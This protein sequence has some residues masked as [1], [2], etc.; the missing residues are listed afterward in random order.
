MLLAKIRSFSNPNKF[1][2][3]SRLGKTLK[4][5]G[6]G[7]SWTCEEEDGRVCGSSDQ[8]CKH[9]K[10]LWGYHKSQMIDKLVTAEMVYLYRDGKRYLLKESKVK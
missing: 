6:G 7:I 9:L 5:G 8:P 10:C 1:Y 4:Q 3:I 2:K